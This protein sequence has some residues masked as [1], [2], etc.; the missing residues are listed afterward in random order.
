MAAPASGVA[1]LAVGGGVGAAAAHRIARA[2]IRRVAAGGGDLGRVAFA[3]GSDQRRV[4]VV[5]VDID[6]AVVA[7]AIG[8][9]DGDRRRQLHRRGVLERLLLRII[10]IELLG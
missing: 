5:E 10:G 3:G 7:A 4:V 2:G 9:A 6:Q 8:A 1:G